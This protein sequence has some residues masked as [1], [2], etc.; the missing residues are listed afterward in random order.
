MFGSVFRYY[1]KITEA[2][3]YEGGAGE[4]LLGFE[5]MLPASIS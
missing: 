3:N 5:G 4:V 1:S 2:G